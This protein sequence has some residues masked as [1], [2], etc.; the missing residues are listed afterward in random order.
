MCQEIKKKYRA[1]NLYKMSC[2]TS[3]EQSEVRWEVSLGGFEILSA[4]RAADGG[5]LH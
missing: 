2:M 4:L 1:I 5:V 3:I